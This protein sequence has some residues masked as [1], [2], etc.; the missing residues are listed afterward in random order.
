[1]SID[2]KRGEKLAIVGESGC[3]KSTLLK[4]LIGFENPDSGMI[5]YD[6]KA[7]NSLNLKSLRRNI[8]SVFQFS[9]VFPG[10]IASNVTFTA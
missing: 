7:I 10:T 6:D 5:Y 2:I 8:G 1:M 4:L 9:K 3:G